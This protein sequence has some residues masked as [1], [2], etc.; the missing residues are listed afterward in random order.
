[1]TTT[2]GTSNSL[3][4]FWRQ[5]TPRNKRILTVGIIFVITIIVTV[6]GILTPLSPAD[7]EQLSNGLNHTRSNIESMDLIHATAAIFENNFLIA[8]IMFIPFFGP[9]F[10][11]YVLYSTGVVLSASAATS[12]FH[13][14]AL[15]DFLVLWIF[16]FTWMEFISYSLAITESVWLA[17]RLMQRKGLREIKTTAI[18]LGIVAITLF[19]AALIEAVL[20][21]ALTG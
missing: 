18:F 1:M 8:L 11:V 12:A 21:K 19:F 7:A 10:G 9:F 2:T 5:L 6:A 4:R 17:G 15:L 14:P 20:I 16:P 13:E 3:L